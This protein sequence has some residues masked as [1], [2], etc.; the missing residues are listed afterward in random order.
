MRSEQSTRLVSRT[1][2]AKSTLVAGPAASRTLRSLRSLRVGSR[3]GRYTTCLQ[4]LRGSSMTRRTR[5]ERALAAMAGGLIGGFA[6]LALA[7]GATSWHWFLGAPVM[8]GVVIGY[9]DGDR[10]IKA[11]LKATRWSA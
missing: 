5:L 11:L 4:F 6:T 8:V 7:F 2:G 3:L 1:L 9:L 10:G